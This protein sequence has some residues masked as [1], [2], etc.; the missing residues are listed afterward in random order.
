MVGCCHEQQA[1]FYCKE[2]WAAQMIRTVL[3]ALFACMAIGCGAS[4]VEAQTVDHRLRID[5]GIWNNQG[6]L[7][8]RVYTGQYGVFGFVSVVPPGDWGRPVYTWGLGGVWPRSQR[9][10]F[11]G[12]VGLLRCDDDCVAVLGDV[13]VE[14]GGGWGWLAEASLGGIVG[15]RGGVYW[16]R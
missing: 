9:L 5:G 10:R 8:G 4:S 7:R 14:Y 11:Q 16:G 15:L 2:I 12:S 1:G 13:G 3:F 6:Y